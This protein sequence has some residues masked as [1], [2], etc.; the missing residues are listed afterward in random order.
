MIPLANRMSNLEE[1]IITLIR[2]PAWK[3]IKTPH[4]QVR[5]T[6]RR[7]HSLEKHQATTMIMKNSK[8]GFQK[9][10]QLKDRHNRDYQKVV[11][12]FNLRTEYG[13]KSNGIQVYLRLKILSPRKWKSFTKKKIVHKNN[14]HQILHHYHLWRRIPANSLVRLVRSNSNTITIHNTNLQ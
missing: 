2:I 6:R 12:S 3:S 9:T 5:K 4:S 11:I 7:S 1:E 10:N 14:Q 13:G 8:N